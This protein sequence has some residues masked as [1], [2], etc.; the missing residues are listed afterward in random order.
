MEMRNEYLANFSWFNRTLHDLCLWPFSTI[1]QPHPVI[2]RYKYLLIIYERHAF[3]SC[4]PLTHLWKTCVPQQFPI[5]TFVKDMCSPAVPHWHI[6]ERHGFPQLFPIGERHAFPSCSP[7][8]HL[9]KT[10]VPQ[11]FP[12][13]ER[14][15]FSSCLT[16]THLLTKIIKY[17]V[18]WIKWNIFFAIVCSLLEWNW[19]CAGLFS[20]LVD[21]Y[22][23]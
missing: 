2:W 3:P 22:C 14:H 7:L 9:W 10:W 20:L 19:I 5:D 6:C 8:T 15:A 12:I 13:G 11:L 21:I 23:C 17:E 1:K 18:Y 16:L 4:S